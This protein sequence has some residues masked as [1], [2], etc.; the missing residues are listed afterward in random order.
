M[1][2]ASI[3]QII[4]IGIAVAGLSLL[5]FFQPAYLSHIYPQCLFH[6][7]TGLYCPGCGSQRAASALLHGRLFQAAGYN[8][9]FLL[10]LPLVGYSAFVFAWNSFSRRKLQQHV[11]YSVG[12]T[13]V[14]LVCVILFAVFRNLPYLPFRLLAP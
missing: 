1:K 11:F 12:F 7:L 6:R 8:L 5:Y 13:R 3:I 2:S 14:F 4:L 10:S 9:M